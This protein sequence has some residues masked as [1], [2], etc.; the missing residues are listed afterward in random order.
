MIDPISAVAVASAAFKGVQQL[1]NAG[2]ELEDVTRHLGKW[3]GAV[4]DFRRAEA[5]SK[6][7]PLFKQLLF[8]GSVEEEALAIFT[9]SK[10]IKQQEYELQV[11]INMSYGP[12]AWDELVQLRRR[13]RKERED[14]I[15]KQAEMRKKFIEF[16][17]I[18]ILILACFAMIA[19]ISWFI[20][21]Q[22]GRI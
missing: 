17:F 19:G 15:Y 20:M 13:I 6:N 16:V 12:K 7:P 1:V 21:S 5:E 2:R 4:S 3:F 8:K 11:I 14:T 10:K 22:T 18:V 9:H